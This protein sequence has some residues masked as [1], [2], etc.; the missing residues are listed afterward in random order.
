MQQR[1]KRRQRQ[2]EEQQSLCVVS[3][4]H[5]KY[6]TLS[7]GEAPPSLSSVLTLLTQQTTG[8]RFQLGQQKTVAAQGHNGVHTI[9][10]GGHFGIIMKQLNSDATARR[11]LSAALDWPPDCWIICRIGSAQAAFVIICRIQVW[12]LL[13][14]QSKRRDAEAMPGLSRVT[15]PAL[16]RRRGGASSHRLAFSLASCLIAFWLLLLFFF[17]ITCDFPQSLCRSS[18]ML[19]TGVQAHVFTVTTVRPKVVT[20]N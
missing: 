2:S 10:S 6:P 8:A 12:N 17:S 14:V 19:P 3:A 13:P 11:C 18:C 7:C 16:R 4:S 9:F 20:H 5:H 15:V 1:T